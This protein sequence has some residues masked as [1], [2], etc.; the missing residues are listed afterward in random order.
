[1]RT[2]GPSRTE[3]RRGRQGEYA[4]Y[5]RIE[6]EAFRDCLAAVYRSLVPLLNFFMPAMK[7]ESKVKAGSQEIRKYDAPRSPFRNRRRCP[8]G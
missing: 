2:F 7:L 3:K 5:D 6:G 8:P 1:L 4:D